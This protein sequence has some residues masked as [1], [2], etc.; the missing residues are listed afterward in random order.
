MIILYL[1]AIVAANLSVAHFGPSVAVLNAFLFIG[2][3]LTTRDALHE[4]WRGRNLTQ[5]ASLSLHLWHLQWPPVL[6]L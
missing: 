3:D 6:I 2:L 1:A 4:R 5:V